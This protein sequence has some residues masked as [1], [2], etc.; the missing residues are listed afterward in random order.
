MID[1]FQESKRRTVTFQSLLVTRCKFN[2]CSLLVLKSLFICYKSSSLQKI[3]RY[4]LQK[5]LLAK[6]HF[7]TRCKTPSLLVAE[8]ARCKDHSLLAVKFRCCTLQIYSLFFTCCRK[9]QFTR[10]ENGPR[11]TLFI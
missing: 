5:S 1:F 10:Y 4:L 9:I 8:V 2:R 6:N 3:S 11:E 7:V